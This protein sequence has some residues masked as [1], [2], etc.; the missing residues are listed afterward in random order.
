MPALDTNVL[1]RY[2]VQDDGPQFGAARALIARSVEQGLPLF[3]PVT[4]MLELEWVLRSSYE[5][6]KDDVMRVLSSLLAAA[7]LTFESE[8]ALELALQLFRDGTADFA[9]CLHVALSV[10]A[11]EQPIWT[12]D[13][14]AARIPG[15]RLLIR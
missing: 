9:D 2:V 3:I 5:L 12:F 11:G 10:Q 14:R 8:R 1:V 6:E 15:A 7:E 4:V 13:K